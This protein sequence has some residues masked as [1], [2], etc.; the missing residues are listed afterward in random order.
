MGFPKI[1][2]IF[3]GKQ[4]VFST[5]N[6]RKKGAVVRLLVVAYIVKVSLN[7]DVLHKTYCHIFGCYVHIP[8]TEFDNTVQ[9]ISEIF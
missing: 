1:T 2:E 5:S 7:K 3:L 8:N 9:N 6:T 4:Q